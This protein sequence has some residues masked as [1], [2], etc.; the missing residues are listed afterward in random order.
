MSPCQPHG[1]SYRVS[2]N[3]AQPTSSD[4]SDNDEKNKLDCSIQIKVTSGENING[5]L[6]R[7]KV[8]QEHLET[9]EEEP[10]EKRPRPSVELRA[11][12]EFRPNIA[13]SIKLRERST[14]QRYTDTEADSYYYSAYRDTV[15]APKEKRSPSRSFSGGGS[16]PYNKKVNGSLNGSGI[17]NTH[18]CVFNSTSNGFSGSNR[19]SDRLYIEIPERS[20]KIVENNTDKNILCSSASDRNHNTVNNTSEIQTEERKLNSEMQNFTSRGRWL[21]RHASH[22]IRFNVKCGNV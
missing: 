7:E 6:T 17:L 14:P 18:I 13:E 15:Y 9:I 4:I 19:D 20:E 5:G 21:V 11:I 16:P 2:A 3:P 1:D 10:A 12:N 22:L 8:R